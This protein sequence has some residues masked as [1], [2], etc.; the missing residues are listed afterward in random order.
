MRKWRCEN[1][2]PFLEYLKN[3]QLIKQAEEVSF[4]GVTIL[5][6]YFHNTRLL[7]SKVAKSTVDWLGILNNIKHEDIINHTHKGVSK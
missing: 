1:H 7:K 4:A 6:V 2:I 3:N 5:D